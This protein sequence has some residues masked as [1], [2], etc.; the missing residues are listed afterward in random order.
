MS[1]TANHRTLPGL[2]RRPVHNSLEG[3]MSKSTKVRYYCQC[4]SRN[5]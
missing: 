3:V 2:R 1:T 5:P 4:G